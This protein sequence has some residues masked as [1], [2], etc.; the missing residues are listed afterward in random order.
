MFLEH[1]TAVCRPFIDFARCWTA[2]D[3]GMYSD[4]TTNPNLGFGAICG[5]SWI[6]ERWDANFIITKKPSIKYLE[7]YAV[8]AAVVTWIHRFRNHRIQLHCDNLSVCH[9]INSNRS[10]CK[11]C[12]VL[13]RILVLESMVH[14]VRIY[15]RHLSSGT[16]LL[17]D[18]LSRMRIQ[19]FKQVAVDMQDKPVKVLEILWS[20]WKLWLDN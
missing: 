1:P 13:I 19:Q 10:S 7:L 14:N 11:N 15:A 4:A 18:L 9:M 5:H 17:A 20:M 12:M 6:V 3:I 8:V 2:T 16:N